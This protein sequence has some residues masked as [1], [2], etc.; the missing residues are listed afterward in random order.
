MGNHCSKLP[1]TNATTHVTSG[2]K[3]LSLEIKHGPSSSVIQ[4]HLETAQKSR[5]LQLRNCGMKI[6]PEQL[7]EVCEI[8]RNLD[9]SQNKIRT[10]PTFIGSFSNLKQLHLSNNELKNLPDEMGVLKKLEVLDLSCNQLNSLPESLA[11]LCSLKTLNISKN[12]F[13]H[14]PVCV[15]H[16]SELNILD[17]SSNLI[18]FLPDE[19]KFLKTS[20]LNLNQNRLNSLNATNLVHCEALRTLRVEENCL[21]KTDFISD[22]LSNSN[23][24]L[25][26]YAGNLFQDKDFQNLP[27]YEEYQNRYT[28][29]KRKM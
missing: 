14:L 10:L 11:G 7:Q 4:R 17:A 1:S 15:C 3:G 27:G 19:V 23:V 8:L 20:E 21:N 16:L 2:R 9:V 6:L 18:E 22:F 28:A 25:I 12:K 5:V 29:T 13:V 26:A 24:S